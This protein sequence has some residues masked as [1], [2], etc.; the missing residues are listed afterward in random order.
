[1]IK[2]Y[3]ALWGCGAWIPCCAGPLG[4]R[5]RG[6]P[7]AGDEGRVQLVVAVVVVVVVVVIV[8]VVAGTVAAAAEAEEAQNS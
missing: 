1:M 7:G 2:G 6:A 5:V 3:W 4:I 8:V